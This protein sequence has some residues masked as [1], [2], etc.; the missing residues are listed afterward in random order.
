MSYIGNNNTTADKIMVLE[1]VIMDELTMQLK[2][3]LNLKLIRN[4]PYARHQKDINYK[5]V[6]FSSNNLN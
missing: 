3:I 5:A 6:P 1:V 2:A 4:S